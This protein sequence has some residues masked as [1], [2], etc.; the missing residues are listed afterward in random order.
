MGYLVAGQA[1]PRGLQERISFAM[2][3]YADSD[4][5][6]T[7]RPVLIRSCVESGR[8][9]LQA[10]S[11]PVFSPPAVARFTTNITKINAKEPP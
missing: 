6:K 11:R 8:S 10:R 5:V 9:A 4:L 2:I 3:V 7:N 1:F